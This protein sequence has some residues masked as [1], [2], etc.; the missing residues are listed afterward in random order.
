M[1]HK[2][3]VKFAELIDQECLDSF[4]KHPS[5]IYGLDKNYNIVY[6]NDAWFSFAQDNGGDNEWTLGRNIFDTIPD[7]EKLF[8]KNLF[9]STLKQQNSSMISPQTE[10]ECS[11]PSLY[12]R[13]SMHIYPVGTEGLVVVN[14]LV[15]EEPIEKHYS[16]DSQQIESKDYIDE[17]RCIYQC[18]NCRRIRLLSD[19]N[20][21]AWIPKF[22]SKPYPNT[23]H[24]ICPP[25]LNYYYPN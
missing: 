22:I 4:N 24:C 14:S 17:N 20:K 12:R 25:C 3:S 16:Q 9:D 6:L 15:I 19:S 23:S 10:Y 11:S 8:Y 2:I 21:W 13:Y 1:G 18:A 7:L 5:S